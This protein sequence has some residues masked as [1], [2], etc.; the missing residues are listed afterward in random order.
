MA[1]KKKLIFS[2]TDYFGNLLELTEDTWLNHVLDPTGHPQMSGYENLVKQVVQDPYEIRLSTQHVTG[3]AFISETNVGPRPEGIRVLV[4]F[5]STA[6]EKGSSHGIVMT[7]YPIDTVQ[8]P[9]PQ[10][11]RTIFKKN[12]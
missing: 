1:K 12:R 4:N 8:V 3:V 11:G 9:R 6:Y 7:A 2:T 5:S 10:L